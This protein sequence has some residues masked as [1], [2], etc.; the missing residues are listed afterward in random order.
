MTSSL[1]FRPADPLP[2]QP[3]AGPDEAG[4]V[5]DAQAGERGAFD[6]IV[7]AHHRRVFNFILQLA[8]QRQDAEDLTQQTFLK[9]YQHLGRFDGSRP[10][11]NWLLTIAR[12]S[13][14]N[15]FRSAKKWEELPESAAAA[16]PSPAHAAEHRDR[17]DHLWARARAVLSQR[18]F[19]VLWLRFGEDLTVEE[20][21]RVVGLTQTHVKVLVFRARRALLKEEKSL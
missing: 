7:A 6:R 5:R 21:A 19:E 12:N 4:L 17:R 1:E 8:R 20:T 11:I 3:G 15:H 13:T 10:L 16:E 2:A 18:E 9:A 14:L